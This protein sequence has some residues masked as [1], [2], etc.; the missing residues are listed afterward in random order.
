MRNT[1]RRDTSPELR[2]RS[3]LHRRGLRFRVDV[4]PVAGMRARADVVFTRAKLAV[5][6]DGCFWHSCP[7]HGTLPKHNC[8]WWR[9]KLAMNRE[10]D[11]RVEAQLRMNGWMVLRF[12]EHQDP[13]SAVDQICSAL[14]S[15]SVRVDH[16]QDAANSTPS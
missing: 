9:S 12:W 15:R 13:A 4:A 5:F 11:L 14:R 1:R 10:R 7:E 2:I 8:L 3:L 6:V 16:I